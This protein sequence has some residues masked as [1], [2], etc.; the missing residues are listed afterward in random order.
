MSGRASTHIDLSGTWRHPIIVGAFAIQR[1]AMGLPKAGIQLRDLEADIAFTPDSVR[2]TRFTAASGSQRGS[3]AS[4][5]GSIHVPDWRDRKSLGFDLSL[6][7][8]NFL[9][10]D[11]R[12]V[13][14]I[15]FSGGLRLGGTLGRPVL[16]GDITV[17]RGAL[18]LSDI[19]RKQVVNLNDPE[20]FTLVDTTLEENRGLLETS[21]LLDSLV[22]HL[23]V[24]GFTV[25]IGDDVWLRSEEAN[26][27]LAGSMQLSKTG[28][29]R[30]ESGTLRVS[31]GT[32]RLDFSI[33]QRTFQ[34]D[35]G[36]VTFYGD[37]HIQ[38]ELN[39][40][41]SYTVRQANRQSGQDV[42]I[43]A[44]IA[45]TLRD[46]RLELSSDERFPL[47][48][49][50]IL[51]YIVFG[52]PSF[53][54]TGDITANPALQQVA[55][56]LLPSVGAVLERAL[57]DQ[58]GFIDY[59]QVQTGT[60]G[61]QSVFTGSGAQS[62]LSGTRIG[63]GKQIGER[64]FVTANAGL[65]QFAGTQSGV[66]FGQSLGLTVEQRLRDGFTLQGSIE[67]SSAALQCR[68]GLTTIGSR[69]PQYGLDLFREWSF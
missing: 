37:P 67:P 5:H 24:P 61:Q 45:G 4:L 6:D 21:P 59:V 31:R 13:A 60:T 19:F 36:T 22:T 25:R 35:S 14:R 63:V 57:A 8:R 16:Q 43:I 68:P 32:Y 55:A 54:G 62:F 23:Q 1:G 18:Y 10:L 9:A 15:E 3:A 26:I 12:S 42:R 27:K 66:S 29:Q 47:S 53:A 50:E 65:C 39:V 7:A 41:A 11:R 51:S 58:I 2:I 28:T 38:P 56:A 69:P 17:D 44:H 33:V 48:Q 40:W 20:A 52:Q 49:T 64:T 30:I 34:V 46:P